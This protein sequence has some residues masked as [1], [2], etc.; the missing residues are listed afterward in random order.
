[1]AE[2]ILQQTET[3]ADIAS[4]GML[5]AVL[6]LAGA[7]YAGFRS[8]AEHRGQIVV[9]SLGVMVYIL[10]QHSLVQWHQWAFRFAV[11]VAPWVGVIG[12]WCINQLSTRWRLAVWLITIISSVQVAF[13]AQWQA[14][15]AAWQAFSHPHLGLPQFIYAHWRDWADQLDANHTELR[16]ALPINSPLGSFY[17]TDPLRPVTME[18]LS[19]LHA[20]NAEAAVAGTDSWLVVPAMMFMGREE[21]V[22]GTT[23]LYGGDHA[24][25]NSLAA[26]RALKPGESPLPI[27]YQSTHAFTPNGL[28]R[29][30]LVRAWKSEVKFRL[31]N[32]DT[33]SWR[34]EI[35]TGSKR[36][37]GMLPPKGALEV[38]V[39]VNDRYITEVEMNFQI[40]DANRRPELFPGAVLMRQ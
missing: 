4:S 24:G 34:Y 32:P 9:W 18:K 29:R 1:M 39:E 30:M 8:R 11:L 23:W 20:P 38:S 15:Q 25:I 27:L 10:V 31:A 6:F 16:V 2:G 37:E 35:K 21:K 12:A 19:E 36:T 13:R 33:S 3:D 17:R 14:H 5:S 26:Y 7:F 22:M 28:Q 40:G